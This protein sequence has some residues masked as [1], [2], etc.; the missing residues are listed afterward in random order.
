M[1][2]WL[3]EAGIG[4]AR[5]ALVDGE[6]IIEMA[7]EPEG[8]VRAG[9]VIEARLAEIAIPGKRGL[10]RFEG[11][12]ALVQPLPADWTQGAAHRIEI[13]RE[14]IAEPGRAKRALARPTGAPL[15]TGPELHARIAATGHPVRM[16]TPHDP[17]RLEAAGWTEAIE[18][19]ARGA[20]D[21]PGGS[22]R[23]SPTP[24]MTLIDIDGWL[25]AAELAIAAA[26]AAAAAIRR[27]GIAGSI[28][29]DFPTLANKAERLAAADAFDAVMPQPF[30]RTAINGFG[31][32][33]I[34]RPRPR[35]SLI[36]QLRDD[37]AGS[38]ARA[39]LRRAQH[40]QIIGGMRLV[41]PPPL[42]DHLS[43][44]SDWLGRLS[45][46]I[47]GPVAL[48]IDPALAMS[49]SYAEPNR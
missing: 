49:A 6:T 12:E 15:A 14:A 20:V 11:G 3:Y 40:S 26:R 24:A 38:A 30:E 36:E 47:G 13:T 21:F 4:E 48:R 10:A 1:A 35:A 37:P 19:A 22:L 27:L 39:L 23:I 31:L 29:I 43:A 25:P 33:Q 9:T 46:E 34:I 45:R 7:I 32:M 17:D 41:A 44:R 28:G 18:S 8:Q 5:A 2:E 42:A 16:L